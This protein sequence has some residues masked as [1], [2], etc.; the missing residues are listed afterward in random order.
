MGSKSSTMG[1]RLKFRL[2]VMYAK[3]FLV[4]SSLVN[5]SAF[6]AVAFTDKSFVANLIGNAGNNEDSPHGY[7]AFSMPYIYRQ[8]PGLFLY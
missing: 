2:M 6:I 1:F 5:L 3:W 7:P 4:I 8:R